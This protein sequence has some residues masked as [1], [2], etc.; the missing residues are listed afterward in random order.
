MSTDSPNLTMTGYH[1]CNAD[2]VPSIKAENFKCSRGKH[3]WLGE[4]AYFFTVGFSNPAIDAQKW[5]IAESWDDETQSR[6]YDKFSV[7][8]AEISPTNPLDMSQDLGKAKVNHARSE[9]AKRLKPKQ[10]YD[11]NAIIQWLTKHFG[12][13]VLVQ[14]FYIKMTR[15]RILKIESKFPNVRV[16]CVRDPHSAIDKTSISVTYTALVPTNPS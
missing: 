16:I 1:G 8:K 10:A 14:D 5:A 7:L 11:D 9:I 6:S 12:F 4:G 15:E 2:N 13:D 3:H